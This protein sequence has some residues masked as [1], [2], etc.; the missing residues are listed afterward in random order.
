[1]PR[2]A[3]ECAACGTPGVAPEPALFSFNSAMGACP[4]CRGLGNVLTFTLDR[5]VP[6]PGKTLRQGAVHPWAGSWRRVF[7][8]RIEKLAAEKR[9]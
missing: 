5:I 6:D 1:M 8:P 9:P 4:E 2:P 3:A 7:W